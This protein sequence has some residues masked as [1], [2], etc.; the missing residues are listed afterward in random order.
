MTPQAYPL[1]WPDTM[2]RTPRREKSKFRS[3]LNAALKNVKC[4][5]EGFGRD[6]GK[7]VTQIV[8]SSNCTLGVERP[9][10]PGVAAWFLWDGDSRCIAVDRYLL[11]EENLQ[12][13]HHVIE[14]RRV[15]LRHGTLHLVRAT[16]QGFKALPPP[17]GE[18][19]KKPWWD[20]LGLKAADR[21]SRDAIDAVYRE[22]AKKMHPDTGGSAEAMAALN[23]ARA[24]ALASL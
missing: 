21:H 9:G 24:E 23:A 6:S 5:L 7:P 10:D 14:A 18:P 19:A 20:V 15:E 11:P 2:P 22:L 12:A 16:M 8:L 3:T 17:P 4:S 13:I 1:Q